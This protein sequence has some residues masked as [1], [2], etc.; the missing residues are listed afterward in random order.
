[1]SNF[2]IEQLEELAAAGLPTPAVNQVEFHPFLYQKELL[3][4]CDSKSIQL[5]AYSPLGA[6]APVG[7]SSLLDHPTI[8]ELA[9]THSRSPAQVLVRWSVQL[10]VVCIPKSTDPTRIGQ[11]LDAFSWELSAAD[12][13]KVASLDL[14]H[15][16]TRGFVEGQWFDEGELTGAKL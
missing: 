8:L 10:G 14:G 1:M 13:E 6:G 3:A 7:G 4:Y 12:M 15:R 16:F 2:T 5:M 11:N 9:A